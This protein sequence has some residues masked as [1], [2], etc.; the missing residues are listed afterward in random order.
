MRLPQR[1]RII[2]TISFVLLGHMGRH[3]LGQHKMTARPKPLSHY[4][5]RLSLDSDMKVTSPLVFS[6]MSVT[7]CNPH[8]GPV[9]SLTPDASMWQFMTYDG[10]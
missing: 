7:L 6:L 2:V 4:T 9:L 5:P 3:H 10:V 8:A 1:R